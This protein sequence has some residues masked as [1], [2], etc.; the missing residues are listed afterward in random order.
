MNNDLEI[1]LLINSKMSIMSKT[2]QQK[3]SSSNQSLYNLMMINKKVHVGIGNVGNNI[4]ETLEKVIASEIEGKCIVQGYIKPNSVEIITFSSG[5]V[6]SNNIVF[7]V[8]FQCYVCSPV[9]GMQINC[10]AKHINKAGIRAEVK[11][12]P[13]PVVIFIAR[14]HNYSSQLF[15]QVKEN[16]NINVRVIGQRFELNDTYISIIAEII[17]ETSAN[18]HIEQ[19][20]KNVDEP[21]QVNVEFSQPIVKKKISLLKIRKPKPKLTIKE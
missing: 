3:I 7:E 2:T 10:I 18:K 4:K 11:D 14:D 21:T 12:T 16:D 5:L 13:S 1:I 19:Q 6:S 17:E 9:E 15:S 20:T 8:V